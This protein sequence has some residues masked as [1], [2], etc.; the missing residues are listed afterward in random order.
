MMMMLKGW[1]YKEHWEEWN[2]GLA[3]QNKLAECQRRKGMIEGYIT[4]KWN[5]IKRISAAV[6]EEVFTHFWL[7]WVF[8]IRE[9]WKI[10]NYEEEIAEPLRDGV[11][12]ISFLKAFY[13]PLMLN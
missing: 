8:G 10:A 4:K 7:S 3:K 2:N 6:A 12:S 13:C 1:I 5:K 9:S 11:P